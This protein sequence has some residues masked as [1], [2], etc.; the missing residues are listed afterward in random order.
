MASILL[1][2]SASRN[3][4][5]IRQRTGRGSYTGTGRIYAFLQAMPNISAT[6]VRLTATY[7]RERTDQDIYEFVGGDLTRTMSTAR[8]VAGQ[9]ITYVFPDHYVAV[10]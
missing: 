6:A 8:F 7:R 4:S 10:V 2:T 3:F 5:A 9:D 1:Y